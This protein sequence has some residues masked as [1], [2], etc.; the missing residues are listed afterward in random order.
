MTDNS[1]Q[2]ESMVFMQLK[3]RGI[4]NQRILNTFLTIPRENFVPQNMKASAYLDNAL[5]IGYEQTI[6]QPYVVAL[7]TQSLNPQ[8]N[9]SI[10]EIGTGSGYQAAILSNL[11]K[12]VTS[13]EIIPQLAK[14]AKENLTK[15][16]IDNV[17]I[18]NSDGSDLKENEIFDKIIVTAATPKIPQNW[19]KCLK[20]KGSLVVPQGNIDSQVLLKYKKKDG[21]LE[22][23]ETSIPVRFVPLKGKEGF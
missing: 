8:K 11:C 21:K 4:N 6:S 1:E 16:N 5:P 2:R 3:S 9:E 19:I 12:K 23:L 20:E 18:K 22:L 15:T 14:F 17:K 10:L 13:Y 7:M